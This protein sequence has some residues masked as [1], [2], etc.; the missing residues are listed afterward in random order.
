M[1][2]RLAGAESFQKVDGNLVLSVQYLRAVAALLVVFNHAA[3]QFPALE[4]VVPSAM[5]LAGV[6]LFFVISGFIMVC[7][8][9]VKPRSPTEFLIM[10]TIRIV[11]IYWFFNFVQVLL[12]LL[13]PELFTGNILTANHLI[14]SLLFIPH[15]SPLSPA[16]LSPF[17]KLGWT[18]NYEMFFYALF[19]LS[20][21]VFPKQR[22]VV[23]VIVLLA[24]SASGLFWADSNLAIIRFC[25]NSI[26]LEFALGMAIGSLFV[27]GYLAKLGVI[28]S[29]LLVL[30]GFG[31]LAIGTYIPPPGWYFSDSQP[32][33]SF[34]VPY[35]SSSAVGRRECPSLLQSEM[36]HTRY[37]WFICFPSQYYGFRS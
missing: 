10:R 14:L 2:N 13:T 36:R 31:A 1:S 28:V 19:A 26:L 22:T 32:L 37:I 29:T 5:G 12:I 27:R 34:W 15:P 3:E 30:F 33:P 6:D 9:H 21:A 25:T 4:G 8:T 17:V 23:A 16:D 11:P 35:R 20:M 7:V 18:L 24:L